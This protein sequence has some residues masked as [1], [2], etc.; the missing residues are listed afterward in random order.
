MSEDKEQTH[1]EFPCL[2]P[3]KVMGDQVFDLKKFV[4]ETLE[5][6]VKDPSTIDIHSRESSG[7]KYV[8]VTATFMADSKAQLDTIYQIFHKHKHVKM[9]L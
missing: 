8:S 7:G 2:F 1:F 9:V 3:I 6:H 4:R 5:Q